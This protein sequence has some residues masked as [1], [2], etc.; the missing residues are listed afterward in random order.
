MI[1]CKDNSIYTGITTDLK[2]RMKEHFEK[3]K[4][5]AKYTKKH[6]FKKIETAWSSE[7]RS[8]AL[9]LEYH[10]KRLKKEQKENIIKSN[11]KLKEFLEEKVSIVEYTR[12]PQKDICEI[13]NKLKS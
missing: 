13:N 12:I 5:C 4:K 1:R 2:R 8:I 9:K 11:D 6:K 7:T 10:I 3:N